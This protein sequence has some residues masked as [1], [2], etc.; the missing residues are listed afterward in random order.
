MAKV[1]FATIDVEL[2]DHLDLGI[3][4]HWRALELDDLSDEQIAALRAYNGQ[5]IQVHPADAE[6]FDGAA[7]AMAELEG[8]ATDDATEATKP[9]RGRPPKAK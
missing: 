7:H 9:R 2:F 1:Q 4:K 5:I 8:D 6:A 3:T